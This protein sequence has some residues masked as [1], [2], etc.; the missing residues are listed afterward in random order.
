MPCSSSLKSTL[1]C[2]LLLTLV[3]PMAA[4][5]STALAVEH[6]CYSCHGLYLRDEAPNFEHTSSRLAKYK[7]DAVAEQKFVES[8][9]TGQMFGHIDAHERLSAEAA[10]ALIHWLVEGAR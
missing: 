5:A 2:A 10:K 6:G 1:T 9:R 8:F 3:S 7:G 4:Q